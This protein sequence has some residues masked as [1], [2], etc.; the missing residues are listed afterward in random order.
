MGPPNVF[1][2]IRQLQILGLKTWFY[3]YLEEG[4]CKQ[5]KCANSQ[6][7]SIEF[8]QAYVLDFKT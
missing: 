6:I 4:F 1:C 3:G 7:I 8:R 2:I 5:N